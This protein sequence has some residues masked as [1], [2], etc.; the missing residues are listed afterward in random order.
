MNMQLFDIPIFENAV[1][2]DSDINSSNLFEGKDFDIPSDNELYKLD[3]LNIEKQCN[4]GLYQS[5]KVV[6]TRFPKFDFVSE[7]LLVSIYFE[8]SLLSE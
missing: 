7:S 1:L 3:L 5:G 2:M 8:T 4:M 6:C